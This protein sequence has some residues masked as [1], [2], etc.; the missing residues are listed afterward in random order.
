VQPQPKTL[1]VRSIA[2]PAIAGL[3][4]L[5]WLFVATLSVSPSL[6]QYFHHDAGSAEHSCAA[7]LFAHGKITTADVPP[8]LAIFALLFLFCIP[9]LT[10]AKF[11]SPDFRLGF[12]RA[13]PQFF[14]LL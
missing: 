5:S 3:L 14:G 8:V 1:G 6:H 12:G 4:M 10:S 11:S 9:L 2:K 7:T 13:P